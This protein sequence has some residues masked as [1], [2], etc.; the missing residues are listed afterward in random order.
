M[1]ARPVAQ[2]GMDEVTIDDPIV[3]KALEARLRAKL[4][5]D[6][7]RLAYKEADEAA[8]DTIKRLELPDG[9]ACRVGRFR[10]TSSVV[11][12]RSVAF[13]TSARRQVRIGLVKED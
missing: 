12:G 4:A 8:K 1:G 11:A 5:L 3:E 9:G 13:E 6:P 10:V 2:V 7:V